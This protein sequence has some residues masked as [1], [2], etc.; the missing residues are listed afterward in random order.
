MKIP[1]FYLQWP[2]NVRSFSPNGE[3]GKF[4]NLEKSEIFFQNFMNWN[5]CS[6]GKLSDKS[7]NFLLFPLQNFRNFIYPGLEVCQY[8]DQIEKVDIFPI[9]SDELENFQ[10]LKIFR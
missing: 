7:G 2:R 6:R 1:K 4:S 3:G 8:S 10:K 5:I 9:K